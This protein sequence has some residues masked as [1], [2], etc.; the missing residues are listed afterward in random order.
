MIFSTTSVWGIV[1]YSTGRAIPRSGG[2]ALKHICAAMQLA[3]VCVFKRWCEFVH[4]LGGRLRF[5]VDEVGRDV[6]FSELYE[7]RLVHY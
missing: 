2:F 5:A 6:G 3:S 7:A 1:V 4:A